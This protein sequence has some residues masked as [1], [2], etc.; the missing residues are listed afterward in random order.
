MSTTHSSGPRTI[1][2]ALEDT[3][4]GGRLPSWVPP[5]PRAP[6]ELHAS[7]VT[8]EGE[9]ELDSHDGWGEIRVRRSIPPLPPEPSEA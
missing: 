8:A 9:P 5:P 1:D 4:W 7:E 3:H 2:A 6:K